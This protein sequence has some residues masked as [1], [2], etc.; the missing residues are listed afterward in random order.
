MFTTVAQ[1][2]DHLK[3]FPTRH[4]VF[5][6]STKTSRWIIHEASRICRLTHRS[7][8]DYTKPRFRFKTI[9]HYLDG[10][11]I[12]GVKTNSGWFHCDESIDYLD[13]IGWLEP[14]KTVEVGFKAGDETEVII[15]DPSIFPTQQVT[16]QVKLKTD[17][18]SGSVAILCSGPNAGQVVGVTPR[19]VA[20]RCI[21][22][23]LL[24]GLRVPVVDGG[25]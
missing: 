2:V 14:H 5:I 7:V 23:E 3:R 9:V 8:V 24:R 13:I 18:G 10:R 22:P 16:V 20:K 25:T 12:S 17:S 21:Q 11:V 19:Q 1:A 15:G 6:A 4:R